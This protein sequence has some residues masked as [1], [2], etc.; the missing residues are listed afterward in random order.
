MRRAVD[1]LCDITSDNRR[2]ESRTQSHAQQ[3]QFAAADGASTQDTVRMSVP[4]E[5]EA[6]GLELCRCDPDTPQNHQVPRPLTELSLNESTSSHAA[7]S[8]AGGAQDKVLVRSSE[9]G[10]P[11]RTMSSSEAAKVAVGE[12]TAALRSRRELAAVNS[13]W[14][15]DVVQCNTTTTSNRDAGADVR[16]GRGVATNRAV[17]SN[18]RDEPRTAAVRRRHSGTSP[19]ERTDRRPTGA[20]RVASRTQLDDVTAVCGVTVTSVG[21]PEVTSVRADVMATSWLPHQRH[22]TRSCS[23]SAQRQHPGDVRRTMPYASLDKRRYLHANM[24]QPRDPN[25]P[26]THNDRQT[27]VVSVVGKPAEVATQTK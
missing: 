14:R 12:S 24:D 23:S 4:V 11:R 1:K 8:G 25:R 13:A 18:D 27:T 7:Q 26:A 20:T 17:P 6:F 10:G 21:K 15:G 19:D 9:V 5:L 16:R 2:R 3:S 22:S